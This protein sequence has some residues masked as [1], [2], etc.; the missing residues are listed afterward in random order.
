MWTR[1]NVADSQPA[2]WFD[3]EAEGLTPVSGEEYALRMTFDYTQGTYS[4]EVK[5]EGTEFTNLRLQ[6]PTATTSFPLAS[7]AKCVSSFA[8]V[9]DTLFTSL[10]G[11]CRMVVIG[12]AENETVVLK[13]NVVAILNAAKAAWLNKC[14]GGDKAAAGSAAAGLTGKEFNEAYLL[15]LDIA[16]GERSYSFAI[17]DVKVGDENVAVSVTLKRTGM[18]GGE[19]API[20]GTLK[21]YGASTLEAFKNASSAA[22]EATNL[23]DGDFSKSNTATATF[24]KGENKFFKAKIEE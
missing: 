4:V 2:K 22:I 5:T 18:A 11:T 21:F 14:A 8:F 16:D 9:G 19:A 3:V 10:S 24:P 1:G 6:L 12:F 20:N 23:T 15:N 13:D 17:A 7:S